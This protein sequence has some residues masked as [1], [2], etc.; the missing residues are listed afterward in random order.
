M[1]PISA[2]YDGSL[3]CT[4]THG[5]TGIEIRTDAPK[6]NQ[7]RGESFSPTDLVAAALATCAMTIIGIVARRDGVV[8]EG[9]TATVE[10][11]MVA[12][13]RRRIARLPVH[14]TIPGRPSDA[15]RRSLESAARTCPVFESLRA[16]IDAPMT[17]EYP[18]L[19]A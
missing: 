8:V 11:H 12:D 10:K 9:M 14:F 6:D 5:P 2:L 15:Q 17:F 3:R 7:G 16:D 18:D 1:I 13:P 19:S 4:A